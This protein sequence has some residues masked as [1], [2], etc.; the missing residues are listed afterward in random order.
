VCEVCQ[1]SAGTFTLRQAYNSSYNGTSSLQPTATFTLDG[2]TSRTPAR[3][4][5]SSLHKGGFGS[6][7]D[8]HPVNGWLPSPQTLTCPDGRDWAVLIEPYSGS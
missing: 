4:H 7:G 2:T 6:A 8:A 5:R 3:S 1:I